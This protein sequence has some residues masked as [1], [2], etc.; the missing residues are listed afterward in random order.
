MN[1]FFSFLLKWLPLPL[2]VFVLFMVLTP[3]AKAC[4]AE[5]LYFQQQQFADV[6]CGG[7]D[8]SFAPDIGYADV[9]CN[10]G[11]QFGYASNFAQQV[12]IQYVSGGFRS[13]QR[14]YGGGFQQQRFYGGGG[15]VRQP[16]FNRGFVQRQPVFF[17]QGP[18]VVVVE[19]PLGLLDIAAPFIFDRGF[20]RGR[21]FNRGF[22][23]G[24]RGDF[25]RGR[26]F[27]DFDR[28]RGRLRRF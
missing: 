7:V 16:V 22:G 25:D 13:R 23:R 11:A 27:R 18:E 9:G 10:S 4:T 6:G 24:F 8:A 1:R 20:G 14:F 19:R 21:G 12:P 28:G 26:G 5:E 3:Q 17:D 2:L 15:F